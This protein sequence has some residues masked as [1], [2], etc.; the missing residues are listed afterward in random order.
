[1]Q[2][3]SSLS[4]AGFRFENSP[5]QNIP[6]VPSFSV[7]AETRSPPPPVL[8]PAYHLPHSCRFP[9]SPKALPEPHGNGC[10]A[11]PLYYNG[12]F[13]GTDF[14]RS[15]RH[16]PAAVP[17][18][19]EEPYSTLPEKRHLRIPRRLPCSAEYDRQW[20]CR[21]FRICAPALPQLLPTAG[22]RV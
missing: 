20:H 6:P 14:S 10:S 15:C 12:I 11:F 13:S 5:T 8:L 16:K 18:S 3:S 17:V 21:F 2:P 19:P 4:P 9:G 22:I 1:M 7:Y